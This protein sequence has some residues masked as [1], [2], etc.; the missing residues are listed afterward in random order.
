M[1]KSLKAAMLATA[2]VV[3]G[4]TAHAAETPSVALGKKLFN[5][6]SLGGATGAK[7]CASCHP[8][9]KGVE[10]AWKNPNLVQQ[11]NTCIVGALKGKP[12]PLESVQMKSLVLYHQSLKPVTSR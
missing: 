9:G 2:M 11:I 12:L 6:P 5:D 1:M 8:S 10:N 7:T 3:M 4:L